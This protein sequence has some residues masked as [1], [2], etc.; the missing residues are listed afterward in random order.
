MVP[1]RNFNRSIAMMAVMYSVSEEIDLVFDDDFGLSDSDLCEEEGDRLYAY[2]GDRSLSRE[3]V[4]D[5]SS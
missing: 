5:L 1:Y 2:L 4:E 3:A